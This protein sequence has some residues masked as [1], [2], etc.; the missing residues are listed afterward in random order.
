MAQAKIN[1]GIKKLDDDLQALFDV[2]SSDKLQEI[3]AAIANPSLS[4]DE[5]FAVVPQAIVRV[6]LALREPS[7]YRS[8]MGQVPAE[9]KPILEKAKEAVEK[10]FSDVLKHPGILCRFSPPGT[11]EEA[12]PLLEALNVILGLDHFSS[13]TG[14]PPKM[15]P[16]SRLVFLSTDDRVILDSLCDWDDLLQLVRSIIEILCC[17]MENGRALAELQ[18]VHIP[19]KDKNGQA[20]SEYRGGS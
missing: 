7:S 4:E 19:D 5:L 10:H 11:A 2:V 9:A 20:L 12:S 18:L 3:K 16:V 13:W 15:R 8:L 1:T 6:L 14:T 17:E